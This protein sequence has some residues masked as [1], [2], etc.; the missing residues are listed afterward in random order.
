MTNGAFRRFSTRSDRKPV[1]GAPTS[2]G[3]VGAV[4]NRAARSADRPYTSRRHGTTQS[5]KLAKAE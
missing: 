5:D 4:A 2:S 3:S 1:S